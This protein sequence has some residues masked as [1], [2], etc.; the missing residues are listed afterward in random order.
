[1][2]RQ[3]CAFME[4]TTAGFRDKSCVALNYVACQE[5][6]RS[7]FRLNISSEADMTDP[8]VQTP[9]FGTGW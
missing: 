5:Q 7:I 6:Q 8:E 1:M 3:H 2:A 4:F 9:A